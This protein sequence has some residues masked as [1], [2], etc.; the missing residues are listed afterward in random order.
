V[1]TVVLLSMVIAAFDSAS[2]KWNPSEAADRTEL[3]VKCPVN[4]GTDA[5]CFINI[6]P[7]VL[8]RDALV[9]VIV[10]EVITPVW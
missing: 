5:S 10:I 3:E 1:V 8:S 2:L 7:L 4:A 6:P 9:V